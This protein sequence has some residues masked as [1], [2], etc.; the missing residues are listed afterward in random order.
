MPIFYCIQAQKEKKWK[1]YLA[2][3]QNQWKITKMENQVYKIEVPILE[4]PKHP[5]IQK[6]QEKRQEKKLLALLQEK[7]GRIVLSKKLKEKWKTLHRFQIEENFKLPLLYKIL[8][9][10]LEAGKVGKQEVDL[11]FLCHTFSNE[12]VEIVKQLAKK[13]RSV[14]LVSD[15]ITAYTKLAD[16][17]YEQ[18]AQLV[19]VSNNRK[20][21]L[22]NAKLIMNYDFSKEEVLTYSTNRESTIIHLQIRM[23]QIPIGFCKLVINDVVLGENG[24]DWD[25]LDTN[26]FTLDD[27]VASFLYWKKTRE[28]KQELLES[29]EISIQAL[30]GLNGVIHPNELEKL[31]R[32]LLTK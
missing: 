3:L 29:L 20:T 24:E 30:K 21:A 27:M 19:T 1:Y 18:N 8:D 23:N 16:K 2:M 31:A 6:W 22:K 7:Q 26:M 11:Y 5:K 32:K 9:F 4:I 17:L 28:E 12:T 15:E 13:Y 14:N 25:S 10:Y